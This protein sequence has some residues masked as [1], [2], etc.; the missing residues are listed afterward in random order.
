M[1]KVGE[2]YLV[3]SKMLCLILKPLNRESP[4][5]KLFPSNLRLTLDELLPVWWI[6]E[7]WKGKA[8]YPIMYSSD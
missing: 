3:D 8:M 5:K 1:I 4:Q 7:C 6:L 2:W